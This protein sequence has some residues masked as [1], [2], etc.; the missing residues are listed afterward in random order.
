MLKILDLDRTR[1]HT[2]DGCAR[3]RDRAAFSGPAHVNASVPTHVFVVV[4]IRLRERGRTGQIIK[5]VVKFDS[6][7]PLSVGFIE[8]HYGSS[9][10]CR[11]LLVGLKTLKTHSKPGMAAFDKY[12]VCM[13][14]SENSVKLQMSCMKSVAYD[15]SKIPSLTSS[16][17]RKR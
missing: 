14:I 6:W 1:L 15:Y 4:S 10:F 16:G 9:S 13:M 17:K 5:N 2:S 8:L 7:H 11:S 12:S 3:M